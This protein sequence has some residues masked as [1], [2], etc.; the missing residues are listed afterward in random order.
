[1]IGV[2]HRLRWV[3][4][5]NKM[6]KLRHYDNLGTARFITIL[7]HKRY[8]LLNDDTAKDIFLNHLNKIRTKYGL[9]L[10]AYV[11]M[12][13]HVHLVIYPE[14]NQKIGKIIGE[15]KSTSAREIL[16][17]FKDNKIAAL[18]DIIVIRDGI[19]RHAFW[20]RRC[21]DHNCRGV[22]SV[23]EKINYC[24]NNPVKSNLVK[25]SGEWLWSSYNHYDGKHNPIIEIDDF[26]LKN[27]TASGGVP[28]S[29]YNNKINSHNA[30]YE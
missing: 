19:R 14:T 12:P 15:L 20:Y 22:K 5:K 10:L 25:E 6:T 26:E 1:M 21:Y 29:Q 9:K 2:P 13:N 4:E 24:H 28:Q 7:C 23:L 27:P 8:N 18:N 16:N 3:L 30:V 17:Y 11:I